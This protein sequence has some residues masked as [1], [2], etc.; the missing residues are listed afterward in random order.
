M[1]NNILQIILF[2]FQK[3]QKFPNVSQINK[4]IF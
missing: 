4:T 1:H 2:K 3:I